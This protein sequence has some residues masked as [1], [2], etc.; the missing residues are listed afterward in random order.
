M[1]GPCNHVEKA[2]SVTIAVIYACH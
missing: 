2:I 1:T